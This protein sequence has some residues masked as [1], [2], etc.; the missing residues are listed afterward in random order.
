MDVLN[1]SSFPLNLDFFP[2]HINRTEN[3][4]V[5]LIEDYDTYE[6]VGWVPC[7]TGQICYSY[8][9]CGLGKDKTKLKYVDKVSKSVRSCK[10]HKIALTSK[11]D[12]KDRL[13]GDGLWQVSLIAETDEKSNL[14]GTIFIYPF[15][16]KENINNQLELFKD[17]ESAQLDNKSEELKADIFSKLKGSMCAFQDPEYYQIQFYML[18]SGVSVF[19]VIEGGDEVDNEHDVYTLCRQSFYY[20]KFSFHKHKHHPN[21]VDSLT[22]VHPL[23]VKQ[24]DIGKSL[25]FDMKQSLIDMKRSQDVR[26]RE[27]Q[28]NFGGITSYMRSLLET[29]N[30]HNLITNASYI[31]ESRFI[32]NTDKS[33][34]E[35]VAKR[36]KNEKLGFNSRG[37]ARQ[38]LLLMFAILAPFI[39][40][41]KLNGNEN[42][43][44]NSFLSEF[45]H[46]IY[47]DDFQS[48]YFLFFI[49]CLYSFR[50][51]V[52]YRFSSYSI[53]AEVVYDFVRYLVK[54]IY[55][56]FFIGLGIIS[57]AMF[58][59]VY[60][61]YDV[62]F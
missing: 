16:E 37:E 35:L 12:W 51:M 30:S 7:I 48:I 18:E 31:E 3:Q 57:V 26:G 13:V 61:L 5:E 28:F 54:D 59:I 4:V 11:V 25:I 9:D 1:D 23:P 60:P 2:S 47:V 49:F 21:N 32:E 42:D 8:A 52:T 14:H 43:S 38:F 40:S 45:L 27:L 24:S 34:K 46:G 22:T 56:S 36:E 33:Y 19:K 10:Q 62:F 44:S 41:F 17:L 29:C 53:M 6:Y 39:I 20:L 58:L 50:R 55:K 15:A